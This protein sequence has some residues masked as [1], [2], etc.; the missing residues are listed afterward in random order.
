MPGEPVEKNDEGHNPSE[1]QREKERFV[2]ASRAK[3]PKGDSDKGQSDGQGVRGVMVE[4]AS[5]SMPALGVES[6]GQSSE[7]LPRFVGVEKTRDSV[8]PIR[9]GLEAENRASN[10]GDVDQKLPECYPFESSPHGVDDNGDEDR[11]VDGILD[12][13]AQHGSG[14]QDREQEEPAGS[15]GCLEPDVGI[16]REKREADSERIDERALVVEK[17]HR[18]ETKQEG[19]DE[20]ME[21]PHRRERKQPAGQENGEN[22]DD[23][24]YDPSGRERIASDRPADRRYQ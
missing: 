11:Q 2:A 1:N 18:R 20:A 13:R 24:V 23:D 14:E 5:N 4:D 22:E 8:H 7:V 15:A 10:Y 12:E 3:G 19:R 16:E 6:V 21:T 9:P 17:A